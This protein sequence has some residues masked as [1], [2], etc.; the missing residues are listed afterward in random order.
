MQ[1]AIKQSFKDFTL[2]VAQQSSNMKGLRRLKVPVISLYVNISW[3]VQ[4]KIVS[5]HLE[6]PIIM[7]SSQ[8][9]GSY[10]KHHVTG[11]VHASQHNK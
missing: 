11:H 6:K 8:S 3:L 7:H 5:I 2:Y 4:F 10:I 9:L 1:V